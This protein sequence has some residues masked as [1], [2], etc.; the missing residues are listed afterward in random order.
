MLLSCT[1]CNPVS[2][3][4]YVIS[5]N[6]EKATLT[7]ITLKNGPFTQSGRKVFLFLMNHNW[8][9]II[10]VSV[11]VDVEKEIRMPFI[12]PSNSNI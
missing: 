11:N 4:S 12:I 5:P 10:G 9:A 6:T 7:R 8:K 3:V 1:F 2:G